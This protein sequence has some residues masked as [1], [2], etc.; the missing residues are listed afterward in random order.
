MKNG[1]HFYGFLDFIS[2][3]IRM[4]TKITESRPVILLESGV[5]DF[6]K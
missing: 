4:I 3:A 6:L 2:K 1:V 5:I